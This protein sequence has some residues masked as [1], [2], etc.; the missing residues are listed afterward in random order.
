MNE[1]ERDELLETL[2]KQVEALKT[3]TSDVKIDLLTLPDGLR[4]SEKRLYE[5]EEKLDGV[6]RAIKLREHEI[7]KQIYFEMH[8][9]KHKYSNEKLRE[10]ELALRKNEDRETHS[11]YE[12][13]S[14]TR[15]ARDF[16]KIEHS[17]LHRRY[18]AA[19]SLALLMSSGV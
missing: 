3:G 9:G 2:L 15:M 8:D 11:L 12:T 19:R 1:E 10:G 17:W 6:T 18:K 7:M 16:E 14:K 4:K 5:L 13:Y